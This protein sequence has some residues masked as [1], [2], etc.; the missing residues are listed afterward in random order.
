MTRICEKFAKL[1]H[2]KFSTNVDPNKS[3]TKCIVFS[4]RKKDRT[5]VAPIIL[6]DD[7]L[8]WV[9]EVKHLGNILQCDNSMKRD[10]A[11]KR[12]K[13]IGKVNSLLQELHFA[14]PTVIVRLL[15]VYCTSFYGSSLWDIYSAD[16]DRLFKSWNVSIRNI[17]NVPYT[18]HRYLI[19]PMSDCPHPKTMISSRY[20]KFTQSLVASTKPSVSYLARLVKDDNRTLMGRTISRISRETNVAKVSLTSMAVNKAMVYFPVPD[21]QQWRVDMINELLN[22]RGNLLSLNGITTTETTTM[23]DYLCSS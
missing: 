1:K 23:I 6:N 18:M 2:L 3:K 9:T 17:F 5:D 10:V 15:K 14:D 20:V 16:V 4:P 7:P 21:D 11:V 8:P 22:V 12:G 13:F 19:E